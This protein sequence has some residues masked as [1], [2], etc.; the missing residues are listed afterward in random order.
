M[1][2]TRLN[3]YDS[4]V[5]PTRQRLT[6]RGVVVEYG[7]RVTDVDFAE[8][9]GGR[10]ASRISFVRDGEPGRYDLGPDEYAVITI[11]SMTADATH[12]DA[13]VATLYEVSLRELIARQTVIRAASAG[14]RTARDG[15]PTS[16]HSAARP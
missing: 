7:T 9:T 15:N 6:D 5:R 16:R 1:R 4:I 12:G 11:G 2:R 13:E 8:G 3:P 10:R 14:S